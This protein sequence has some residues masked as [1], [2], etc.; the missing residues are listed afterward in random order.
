MPSTLQSKSKSL[1]VI[2]GGYDDR[3]AENVEHH[4]ELVNLASQLDISDKVVFLRSISNAQRVMLLT[5]TDVLLYTPE[6]EHFGIVPVEAMH[7]GCIVIACNSGGPLES[8][9]DGKTGF[10]R[11][12]DQAIWAN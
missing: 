1:L 4:D 10:L 6:N 12:P 5:N 3:L 2:A 7:L 11:A 8:I 9:E